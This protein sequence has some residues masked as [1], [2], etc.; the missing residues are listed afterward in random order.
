MDVRTPASA[1]RCLKADGL[2]QV[3][4]IQREGESPRVLKTWPVNT[5]RLLKFIFGVSPPQRLAKGN[6][7]L[8]GLGIAVPDVLSGPR[9]VADGR[10]L[11][12]DT[13]LTFV[14]GVSAWDLL[15]NA[16]RSGSLDSPDIRR[17]ARSIGDIVACLIRNGRFHRDLTLGNFVIDED[18]R[19]WIVDTDGV[20]RMRNRVREIERML[21][22]LAATSVHESLDLPAGVR[23]NVLLTVLRPL[24]PHVRRAL[25]RDLRS[26]VWV[27]SLQIRRDS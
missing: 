26:Q 7:T 15:Q 27:Q 4:L 23:R 5:W 18:A 24:P 10:H 17:T 21:G 19:V 8:R 25:L 2:R 3:W 6:H 12:V 1:V 16:A 9:L 11:S 14:P 20:R 13:E 22:R